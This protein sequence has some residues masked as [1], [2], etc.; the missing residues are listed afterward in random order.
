LHI[1]VGHTDALDEASVDKA[2][3]LGPNFVK[4]RVCDEFLGVVAEL[5]DHPVDQV[6]V[7]VLKLEVF[8][9]SA[10]GTLDI[11]FICLV[12]LGSDEDFFS[13][14][15]SSP[16]FLEGFTD[17]C[18]VVVNCCGVDVA[19][20]MLENAIPGNFV[21]VTFCALESAK[22]DLGIL[23]PVVEGHV[24]SLGHKI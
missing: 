13:L 20:A 17:G 15:S 10:E 19:V 18:F 9:R 2:L 5:W 7:D 11:I 14:N 3:Q 22:T 21:A 8:Q 23:D 6:E 4:W 16:N 12:Q 24:G 1:A